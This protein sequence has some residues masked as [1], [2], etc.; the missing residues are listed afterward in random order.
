MDTDQT[1]R[2]ANTRFVS[3]TLT[4]LLLCG[5]AGYIIGI[6][7]SPVSPVAQTDPAKAVIQVAQTH[8]SGPIAAAEGKDAAPVVVT[9]PPVE[10]P[11]ILNMA[12]WHVTR[13]EWKVENGILENIL[14]PTIY[15]RIET[16]KSYTNFHLTV[17]IRTNNVRYAEV[18]LH[19]YG[20]VFALDFPAADTWYTLDVTAQGK[21]LKVSLNG[22]AAVLLAGEG[23]P[24]NTEGGIAFYVGKSG[25]CMLK[26]LLIRPQ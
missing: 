22:N 3:L 16:T 20:Q 7:T 10:Q 18:Q 14:T 12:D 4:T 19:G 21:D 8:S 26:D 5:A 17:K 6:C 23:N 24:G 11:M 13:G 25:L 1:S 15:S 2:R 9:T